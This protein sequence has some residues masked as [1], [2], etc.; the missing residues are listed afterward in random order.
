[1]A[2]LKK[3]G[4]ECTFVWGADP[5][6]KDVE[7]GGKPAGGGWFFAAGQSDAC[8]KVTVRAL[9][10]DD[11]IKAAGERADAWSLGV[12]TIDG[13]TASPKSSPKSARA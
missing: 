10:E 11:A 5:D 2:I 6:T 9:A 1:M 3:S 8:T 7:D 4:D 13:E 12:V